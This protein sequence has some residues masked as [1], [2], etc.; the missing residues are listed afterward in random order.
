MNHAFW[1]HFKALNFPLED[2]LQLFPGLNWSG[3]GKIV[4]Q[5][6]FINLSIFWFLSLKK[7]LHIIIMPRIVPKVTV[8]GEMCW[9]VELNLRLSGLVFSLVTSWTTICNLI[10]HI[11]ENAFI[12]SHDWK[13]SFYF[14]LFLE[15][16]I[17]HIVVNK[18]YWN[19]KCPDLWGWTGP[20]SAPTGIWIYFKVSFIILMITN[21]H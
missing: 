17:E 12:C 9:L 11:A 20:S 7:H 8:G 18:I 5:T 6:N 4:T 14:L 2:D 10:L 21:Y 16:S 15:P 3:G 1:G 19:T 13:Y